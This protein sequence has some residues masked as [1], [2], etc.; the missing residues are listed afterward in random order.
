VLRSITPCRFLA[1][2][3]SEHDFDRLIHSDRIAWIGKFPG[4]VVAAARAGV[5]SHERRRWSITAAM[6]IGIIVFA[7][8]LTMSTGAIMGSMKAAEENRT[9]SRA[10][11]RI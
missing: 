9:A 10:G 1:A 8:C 4:S 6:A 5:S 2:V 11:E 7:G 3:S